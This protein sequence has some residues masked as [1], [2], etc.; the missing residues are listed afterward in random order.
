MADKTFTQWRSSSS[1]RSSSPDSSLVNYVSNFKDYCSIRTSDVESI[2]VI[3]NYDEGVYKD[4]NVYTYNSNDRTI[5][6]TEYDKVTCTVYQD[7]YARGN[8]QG[9]PSV[10]TYVVENNISG[11]YFRYILLAL[12]ACSVLVKHF[13]A[14]ANRKRG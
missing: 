7:Y 1:G 4:C 13:H 5:K 3:G 10:P 14:L 6:K 8:I 12:L 2:I 9:V 11:I